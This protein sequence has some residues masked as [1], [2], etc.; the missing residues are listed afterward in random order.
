MQ[1]TNF[2]DFRKDMKK[3]LDRVTYDFETVIVTR[4]DNA[5]V[6]VISEKEYNNLME[7]QHVLGNRTNREWLEASKKQLEN[8]KFVEHKLLGTE[9][10]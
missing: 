6:V 8:G 4:K 7:N 3:Y 9:N 10:D 1:A 2:S 5:N